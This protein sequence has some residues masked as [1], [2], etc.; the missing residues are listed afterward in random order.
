[1]DKDIEY[2]VK[3]IRADEEAYEKFK[4]I[5]QDEFNNQGQCFSTLINLYETEKSKHTL[6][7][8]KLEIES[9]QSYL[10]KMSELFLKSLEMNHE[11][12]ERI[13]GEF[14]KLLNSKDRTIQD[15]QEKSEKNKSEIEDL[16]TKNEE[17]QKNSSEYFNKYYELQEKYNKDKDSYEKA[18]EDKDNLNKALTDTC[19]ERKVQ[20]DRLESV[21]EKNKADIDDY[22]H[23]K[24]K[25]IKIDS[26]NKDLKSQ[27]EKDK[28]DYESEIKSIKNNYE[29]EKEK[30]LFNLDKEHQKELKE[31]YNKNTEEIKSYVEKLEKLQDKYNNLIE[32]SSLKNID[33]SKE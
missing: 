5:A 8:R 17:E 20:V 21:I 29:L 24:D 9:F 25:F 7:E 18:L 19:N 30:A 3:S 16:K 10:N 12:E 26:E 33:E 14:E 1:M 11:A 32:Q 27:L 22:V 23:L 6:V 15:L 28:K 2:K 31:I 4:A 13:R